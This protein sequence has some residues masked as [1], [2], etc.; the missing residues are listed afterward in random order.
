MSSIPAWARSYFK[1]EDRSKIYARA[2][3]A[4]RRTGVE[5]VP[6]VVRRSAAV[7]HIGLTIGLILLFG[8]YFIRFYAPWRA[9]QA[10]LPW[11]TVYAETI[12][13]AALAWPLSRIPA[14]QRLFV[15]L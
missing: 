1:E 14:L 5:M 8:L 4:E 15:P 11:Y 12:L 3:E 6:I 9:D 13:A 10:W 7:G 2:K